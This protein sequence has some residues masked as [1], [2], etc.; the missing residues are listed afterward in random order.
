MFDELTFFFRGLFP[1]VDVM[2][3]QGEIYVGF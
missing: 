1:L 2:F 3:K